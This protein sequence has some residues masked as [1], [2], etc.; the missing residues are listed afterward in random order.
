MMDLL[1]ETVA[2]LHGRCP[3]RVWALPAGNS[4][5]PRDG[6]VPDTWTARARGVRS[7]PRYRGT[8]PEPGR[9]TY[10]VDH[11]C[12]VLD[13]LD[14]RASRLTASSPR[15]RSRQSNRSGRSP[16]TRR[17]GIGTCRPPAYG[18]PCSD[19]VPAGLSGAT[20]PA[21]FCETSSVR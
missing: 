3:L 21:D 16:T 15:T 13:S 8:A 14:R 19:G 17:R 12:T 1:R 10:G 6:H 9:R 2:L 4:R 5:Y 18:R 11:E 20:A 7:P